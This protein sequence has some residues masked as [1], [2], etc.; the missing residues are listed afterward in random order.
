MR[1]PHFT[2]RRFFIRLTAFC[3]CS[4]LALGLLA[5]S[6]LRSMRYY[7]AETAEL[8][9][10]T[11]LQLSQYSGELEPALQKAAALS[12]P[13]LFAEQLSRISHSASCARLCLDSLPDDAENYNELYQFFTQC[14]NYALTLQKH[15]T[16]ENTVTAEE[17]TALIHL[18]DYANALCTALCD[19]TQ[20]ILNGQLRLEDLPASFSGE[21]NSVYFTHILQKTKDVLLFEDIESSVNHANL[22]N[23]RYLDSLATVTVQN[24]AEIAA[25]ILDIDPV[26]LR[27][28]GEISQPVACYRFFYQEISVSITKQGGLLHQLLSS[29][30]PGESI[31][32]AQEASAQAADFLYRQ[33]FVSMQEA[34]H[35]LR[36]GICTLMFVYVQDGVLY[37]P[38]SVT[39][40]VSLD[41]GAVLNF[42]ASGFLQKH[43]ER[44]LPSIEW[45]KEMLFARYSPEDNLIYRG[46]AFVEQD[47]L[48]LLC[49][50][51]DYRK[52]G[53]RYLLYISTQNGEEAAIT[54]LH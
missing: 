4:F 42:D 50:E 12:Q 2:G 36:A 41:T 6:S 48:Q 14:E 9:L 52:A 7:R 45:T 54:L 15:I 31:L 35:S 24:A 11:L 29:S 49:H 26:L 38:D 18:S 37:Y 28:D 3:L 43:C 46:L 33:G 16:H 20:S 40:D 22:Q 5:M 19:I 21:D 44:K 53:H 34:Y 30:F 25:K 32:D 10:R 1:K 27:E 23:N 51:L 47:S 39:V 8:R 13:A 17:R